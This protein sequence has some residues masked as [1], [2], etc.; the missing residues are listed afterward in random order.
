[1][2][3]LIS[4]FNLISF[5]QFIPQELMQMMLALALSFLIGLQRE[6][7]RGQNPE[8]Y[9][10]GGVRTFPIIGLLG[11]LLAK[12]SDGHSMVIGL[13]FTVLGSFLWLSYKKKL[14]LSSTAGMTTEVSGLLTFLIGA[15]VF[16]RNL[17]A[18]VT[19][20]VLTLLLLELKTGLE[21]M[22]K[23]IPS[24]E[25]Y[26]FTRFLLLSAVILP[27]VPHQ[28]FTDFHFNLHT[29]WLMVI[30]ISSISYLA[31]LINL[32]V[33]A[34]KSVFLSAVLGGLYSST[35]TTVVLAKHSKEN[36][37]ARLYSG[38]M[39]IASGL[40]YFRV[41]VLLAVFNWELAS[42]VALVFLVLGALGCL[43]G[44]F[45]AM[46]GTVASEQTNLESKNPLELKFSLLFVALFVVMTIVTKLAPQLI[47]KYG[48]YGLS[49][50]SGF[51][52]V[53]PFIMSLSQSSGV[54][55]P[56]EMAA[57]AVVIATASNNLLKGSYAF[58][59]GSDKVRKEAA[60]LFGVFSGLG[61]LSL[62]F[63]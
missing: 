59:L 15:L 10:F 37:G 34:R 43:F 17:W 30:V 33:G 2:E 62:L 23:K 19:A 31:Y 44:W 61:F 36:D 28:D 22:A 26:T 32:F 25:I 16:T 45:W 46:K 8:F 42:R 29:M 63:L 7:R 48:I 14:E 49:F 54:A 27:V 35:L 55:T 9:A 56:L 38:A 11:F 53:D 4:R 24:V 1:M 3:D 57:I 20:T 6:E 41:L 13:G 50:V 51:T 18:A 5:S 21:Q 39:I 52:D 58:F 60:I 47:G 40:M 12:L